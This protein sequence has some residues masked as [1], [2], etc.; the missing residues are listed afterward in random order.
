MVPS[1]PF[2]FTL[3]FAALPI[4][5]LSAPGRAQDVGPCSF[6]AS[7]SGEMD[8]DLGLPSFEGEIP[9]S[10][11]TPILRFCGPLGGAGL[12]SLPPRQEELPPP[13]WDEEGPQQPPPQAPRYPTALPGQKSTTHEIAL[14]AFVSTVDGSAYDAS[15]SQ[16]TIRLDYDDLWDEG[17]G[18]LVHWRMHFNTEKGFG[19]K[20]SWGPGVFIEGSS[21]D[22][23]SEVKDFND[24][25]S[26][27][28][29]LT[30]D[31][32]RIW[33]FLVGVHGRFILRRFYLGAH[34]GVGLGYIGAVDA[35]LTSITSPTTTSVEL[36]E[37]TTTVGF[38]LG[39]RLGWHWEIRQIVGIDF[40]TFLNVGGTGAPSEGEGVRGGGSSI[41]RVDADAP[42]TVA[43][44]LGLA[45][46]LGYSGPVAPRSSL[47][48]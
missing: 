44:G 3:A 41:L 39:F 29:V 32:L 13:L 33:K 35:E 48:R 28:E 42:V 14:G 18:A 38:D 24:D 20:L 12:A 1:R 27:D 40:H 4:L 8:G 34:A 30:P 31:D 11:G 17:G 19:R 23:E 26:A 37:A 6:E 36:Y 10:W 2:R 16:A 7:E 9:S 47:P 46:E 15:G 25:G 43:L 22:G 21:Y 45:I 5:L